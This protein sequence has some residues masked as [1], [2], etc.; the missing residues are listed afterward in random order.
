ME[1]IP[2]P[3]PEPYERGDIV[4]VYLDS[5]DLDNRLHNTRCEVVGVFEDELAA[6]TDRE[7]D[8]FTY[9]VRAIESDNTLD[10]E[11][12]HWDIVPA[13]YG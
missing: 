3:S 7:L 12:R 6:E 2:Q 11:F 13:D 10:V 9:R 5:S 8:R 1:D 4:R